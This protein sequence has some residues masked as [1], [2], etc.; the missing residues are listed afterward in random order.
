MVSVD[1]DVPHSE[2]A[3]AGV[4]RDLV[5]VG[6][7][8][9]LLRDEFIVAMHL[10]KLRKEGHHL[11]HALPPGVLP[12]HPPAREDDAYDG[13][14]QDHDVGISMYPLERFRC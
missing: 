5:D 9:F 2:V 4:H 6:S 12:A 7:K 1:L 14:A 13:I 8:G 3:D 10:M 11:P